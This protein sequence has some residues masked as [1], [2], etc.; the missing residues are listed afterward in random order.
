MVVGQTI[1]WRSWNSDGTDYLPDRYVK[2][3]KVYQPG[4]LLPFIYGKYGAAPCICGVMF[5][6]SVALKLGGFEESI[7]NLYEDQVFFAKFFVEESI[8]V[9]ASAHELYR[10]HE[11]S[12]WHTSIRT[13]ED[14]T[15]LESYLSW[16]QSYTCL[17]Y[18]SPS[19]RDQ[20]G[21]RMPS[22]A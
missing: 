11:N 4:E 2:S 5:R 18:T 1:Y 17:L 8:F 15:A 13:G 6:R 9:D 22:S 3:G 7:Q 16:L 14:I 12:D 19:P 20:R 10:Q 21:S